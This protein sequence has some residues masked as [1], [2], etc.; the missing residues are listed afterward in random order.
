M[1][2]RR[3]GPWRSLRS[4]QLALLVMLLD[5]K[6]LAIQSLAADTVRRIPTEAL[7]PFLARPEVPEVLREFFKQRG[8][9]PAATP[10]PEASEPLIDH[11]PE[12]PAQ[13]DR[14]K[15]APGGCVSPPD[16][17]ED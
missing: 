8:I 4:G 5:D 6:D 17:G 12:T 16:Y 7:A 11:E 15:V 10:A 1:A 2:W 3:E 9:E 14:K 13:P